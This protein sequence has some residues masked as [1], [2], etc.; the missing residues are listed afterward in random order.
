MSA[1]NKSNMG[2]MR[3]RREQVRGGVLDVLWTVMGSDSPAMGLF[4]L[5]NYLLSLT[6]E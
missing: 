3:P 4:P 1:K 2:K 5:S 6:L